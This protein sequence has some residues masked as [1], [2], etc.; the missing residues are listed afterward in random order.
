MSSTAVLPARNSRIVGA[1]VWVLTALEVAGMGVAGLSKFT[2]PALWTENFVGWG[3]PGGFAYVIGAAELGLALLLLVPRLTSWA[4]IGLAGIMLGALATVLMHP[5]GQ[6]GPVPPL[7]HVGL[8]VL[9]ASARW[10]RRWRPSG[11]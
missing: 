8:L 11:N 9:L 2:N 10:Q 5:G 6:M 3:Y 7:V 1:L 4:A